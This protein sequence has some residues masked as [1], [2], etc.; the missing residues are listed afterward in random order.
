M[1]TDEQ[2]EAGAKALYGDG[3]DKTATPANKKFCREKVLA[4]IKAIRIAIENTPDDDYS[5][6][7]IEAQ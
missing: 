1:L 2:L 5:M 7:D 6:D 4:I 3:W